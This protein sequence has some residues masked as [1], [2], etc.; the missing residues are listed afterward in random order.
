MKISVIGKPAI[1][2][3]KG[4]TVAIPGQQ[5][6]ALLV[7]LLLA[8][9]PLSRRTLASE[10]FCDAVDPL[11]AL[12]WSLA[13]LRRALGP[14]TLRGNPIELNLPADVEVD[15]WNVSAFRVEDVEPA[16]LLEGIEP[17][18]SHE[19]S[20]WLLIAREQLASQLHEGL[21]R[22]TIA[23]LA[24]GDAT[25][26]IQYAERSVRLRPFDE[27]GHVLLVKALAAAGKLNA[28]VA[29]IEATERVFEKELGERP[30]QALRLA[31]RRNVA[32]PPVGVS[33][34]SAIDALVKSG[35]AALAAGAIDAGIDCLRQAAARAETFGNPH[36]IARAFHELGTA[37]V[38]AVR[39]FDEEGA[40]ML[41]KAADMAAGVGASTLA[42]G[43]LR[44]LGYVDALAG[45]RPSASR[46][47][48]DALEFAAGNDDALA[49][50]HAMIGFNLVD[51]GQRETGL[52]H[53]E[54]SI[55]LARKCENRRREIW[56]LGIGGWGQLRAGNA[57]T[58]ETWLKQCLELCEDL[59]W[60]AFEPW[61]RAILVEARLAQGKSD[62][63]ALSVL[64]ESLALSSQLGDPCWEAANARSLA[65]MKSD[66]RDYAE[67]THWLAYARSKCCGVT[68]P[69]A[70]LLVEIV[71]DQMRLY[72]RSGD[73][74]QAGVAARDLLS[75][76]A[77]THADSHIELALTTIRPDT[78]R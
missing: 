46:H 16:E 41:R 27:S 21:R 60:I 64:Q 28:A 40:I 50:V 32:D 39:G 66:A 35:I 61:P 70:G 26:A 25:P 68:D 75:L 22:A 23:A 51:W 31:A 20:T 54:R 62:N 67:A 34:D 33:E 37:L 52:S 55:L 71:A 1:V 36:S 53:F 73:K 49:G 12:R 2:N 29:H 15:L 74:E 3:A 9:R 18:A 44:E 59:R 13:S 10:L 58:A 7:R 48:Q 63:S 56:S 77:R 5:S 19:F 14:E 65:L 6:W 11:G 47:L 72:L 43:S 38:H 4:E 69:Y 17:S 30:S 45:R 8:R 78:A 24:R 42:A 57:A 76:A